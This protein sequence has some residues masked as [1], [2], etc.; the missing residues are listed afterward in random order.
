[1]KN[2]ILF[3]V[4][5]L[6]LGLFAGCNKDNRLVPASQN[7]LSQE[8]NG[9]TLKSASLKSKY[10]VVLNNDA[11]ISRSGLADKKVKMKK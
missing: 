3:L 1:M 4:F 5:S 6:S 9:S 8:E 10:I 11:D 2:Q 7:N